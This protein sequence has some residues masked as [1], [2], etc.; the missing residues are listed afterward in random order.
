MAEYIQDIVNAANQYGIDPRIALAIA[1]RETG[2]D[3]VNSIYMADNGGLMQITPYSADDYGVSSLYPNWATDPQQNALGGMLILKKK[4]E[5][6]GG[7]VWAG[8]KAYNGAGPAADN[9]VSQ[10]Q[11][12]FNNLGGASGLGGS[13]FTYQARDA[14]G[15]PF[16]NLLTH[17]RTSNP[18]EPFDYQGISSILSQPTPNA[19]K[20]LEDDRLNNRD[21][22][23]E[24]EYLP[25]DV[26]KYVKPFSQQLVQNRLDE[27]NDSFGQQM[28]QSNLSKGAQAVNLINHSNNVDNKNAYSS[29][30][31]MMGIDVPSNTDQYV[32]ADKL[33]DYANQDVASQRKNQLEVDALN[34]SKLASQRA[35]SLEQ[36][37]LD[38]MNR[39]YSMMTSPQTTNPFSFTGT[40]SG[41][42]SPGASAGSS[43][44]SGSSDTQ[45]TIRAPQ[46]GDHSVLPGTNLSTDW[47]RTAKP[48]PFANPFESIARAANWT[49]NNIGP[50]TAVQSFF[51]WVK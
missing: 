47:E 2:G 7:N 29:I 51:N 12:N 11:Q 15:R 24:A 25:S 33:L 40:G 36:I 48:R 31:K 22:V 3:D 41:T 26:A 10:V 49:M 8:V 38:H 30:F 21:Y 44:G 23:G 14:N 39:I 28:L 19:Q 34:A 27:L 18:N 13:S 20:A 50:A 43:A 4:I 17:L 42:S 35:L 9:Y 5:E 45:A 37:K 6:Q 16:L 1:A 46:P 32:G